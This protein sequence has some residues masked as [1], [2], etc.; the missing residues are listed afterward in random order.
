MPAH[1]LLMLIFIF[2]FSL[3]AQ[4]KERT[5]LRYELNENGSQYVKLTFLNQIWVRNTW[6]NPGTTVDGYLEDQ[7]FDIGLRRTRIQ[8]FGQLTDK[9]FFYTQFGT[10][11]L[12]YLGERKQGLFFHDALGELALWDE[13]LSLGTGLTG[14]NGVSRYSSPSVGSILSL[15][16]PLYQQT[17]N[18]VTDQFLRKYSIYVKGKLIAWTT[19]WH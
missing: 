3:A 17:T 7:T 10:N 13:K 15:D 11:N 5:E 1:I 4:Q 2:P 9:V 19:E 8:L 18:D 14:W 6:N 12:T 16:A